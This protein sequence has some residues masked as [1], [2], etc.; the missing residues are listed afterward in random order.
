MTSSACF[1]SETATP[2]WYTLRP[3]SALDEITT[4]PLLLNSRQ[5]R[6]RLC[7]RPQRGMLPR[8]CRLQ[9]NKASVRKTNHYALGCMRARR[10]VVLYVIGEPS[11]GPDRTLATLRDQPCSTTTTN[12][13]RSRRF[14]RSGRPDRRPCRSGCSVCLPQFGVTPLPAGFDHE[15]PVSPSGGLRLRTASA[16]VQCR[17]GGDRAGAASSAGWA[18]ARRCPAA[19][20]RSAP[21]VL[22]W[23]PRVRG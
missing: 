18:R 14:C 21:R 4:V 19:V 22:P 10:R 3:V 6:L 16:G 23:L 5:P 12:N 9:A 15:S 2:I 17:P 13:R 7:P 20:T 1:V 8:G 11:L